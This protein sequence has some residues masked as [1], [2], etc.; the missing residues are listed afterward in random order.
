MQLQ[1]A[2]GRPIQMSGVLRRSRMKRSG[3]SPAI[4]FAFGGEKPQAFAAWAL[5]WKPPS[6]A[7]LLPIFRNRGDCAWGSIIAAPGGA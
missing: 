3:N 6:D 7:N 4:A 2:S 1:G 5:P